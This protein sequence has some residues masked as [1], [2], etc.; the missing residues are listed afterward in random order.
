MTNEEKRVAKFVFWASVFLFV[1]I[2]PELLSTI[3]SVLPVTKRDY[4]IGTVEKKIVISTRMG[5]QPQKE[6]IVSLNN[7]DNISLI[8]DLHDDCSLHSTVRLLKS[9]SAMGF[10]SYSILSCQ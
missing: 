3:N 6:L 8:L 5:S 7:G 4:L 9:T 10:P 1:T 2:L